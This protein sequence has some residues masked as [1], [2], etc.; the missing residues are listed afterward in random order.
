[1][2]NLHRLCD[3]QNQSPWLDNLTRDDLRSGHLQWL[4]R[5]GIRGVTANPTILAHAISGSV[6]YDDQFAQLIHGG[7]DV[8]TAYW[9]L[10]IADVLAAL[11]QLGPLHER[12]GGDDGFVSLEVAPG[13]AYD[14]AES[15]GSAVA[16]HKRIERPNLLVKIP[17]TGPGTDAIRDATAAG[18]SINV[19]LIFSLQRYAKSWRR[20][21]RASR[22][23][24]ATGATCAEFGV[25]RRSL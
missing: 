12:S 20:T 18:A 2:T 8:P 5:Q 13:L 9:E 17:A 6:A 25:S 3:E 1:M 7:A 11:D 23:S 22:S 10:V 4:I 15:V 16:L 14:A 21:F 24:R 19:T